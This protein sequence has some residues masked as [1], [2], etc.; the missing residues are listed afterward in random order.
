MKDGRTQSQRCKRTSDACIRTVP[1]LVDRFDS[2]P[3]ALGHFAA[4]FSRAFFGFY[5]VGY[6]VRRGFKFDVEPVS[7]DGDLVSRGSRCTPTAVF[8]AVAWMDGAVWR[9][10]V[11]PPGAECFAWH[12]NGVSGHV[13][14]AFDLDSARRLARRFD[15]GT[16]T[17]CCALQP[18]SPHVRPAGRVSDGR[19]HRAGLLGQVPDPKP[20]SGGLRRFDGGCVLYP[21]LHC[22][23][24]AGSLAVSADCQ[25]QQNGSG[26]VD[27]TS[28]LVARKCG[29][30]VDVPAVA[31]RFHRFV[32]AHARAE[33]RRRRGLGACG[34]CA[35]TACHDLAVFDPGRRG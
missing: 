13:A 11:R 27:Q 31:A 5:Q 20:V 2:P 29:D 7:P 6:L 21:L 1:Q 30:C 22:V 28:R 25:R 10:R 4:C 12:C 32:T 24:R 33:S 8:H 35:L 14:R 3:R 26:H 16:V 18:G 19:D 17:D 9:R 34:R 23:L 15:A